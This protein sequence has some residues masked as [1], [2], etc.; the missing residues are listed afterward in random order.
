MDG[1]Y[2]Q[3]LLAYIASLPFCE[4]YHDN[5]YC[6]FLLSCH[7][8]ACHIWNYTHLATYGHVKY[9]MKGHA[10]VQTIEISS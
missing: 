2:A 7:D 5:T 1:K 8:N 4:V 6:Y 10:L 9:V 3:G